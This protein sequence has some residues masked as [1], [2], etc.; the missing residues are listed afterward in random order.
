MRTG[1]RRTDG[2]GNG[3]GR[4]EKMTLW[5]LDSVS[6]SEGEGNIGGGGG[7]GEDMYHQVAWR[8]MSTYCS[9]VDPTKKWDK[10]EYK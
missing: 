9:Y 5:C 10:G 6:R 8:R 7:G 3:R 1:L 4:E 2:D